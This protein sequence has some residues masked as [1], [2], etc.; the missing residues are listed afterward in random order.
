MQ[1][2]PKATTAQLEMIEYA[3]TEYALDIGNRVQGKSFLHLSP[4]EVCHL[5]LTAHNLVKAHTS[6][7]Q[8]NLKNQYLRLHNELFCVRDALKLLKARADDLESLTLAGFPQRE[9]YYKNIAELVGIEVVELPHLEVLT[10]EALPL[11][12]FLRC[13]KLKVLKCKDGATVDV[14]SWTCKEFYEF[15]KSCVN[16]ADFL[17]FEVA[18]RFQH[19]D[20]TPALSFADHYKQIWLSLGGKASTQA[21]ERQTRAKLPYSV[22]ARQQLTAST[23]APPARDIEDKPSKARRTETNQDQR[24]ERMA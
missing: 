9:G 11:L 19:A 20:N 15:L 16:T 13:P 24:D 4:D 6:L 1:S 22:V 10:L 7:K 12:A 18:A 8:L 2:L 23:G 17:R 5:I 21:D 3:S 14:S